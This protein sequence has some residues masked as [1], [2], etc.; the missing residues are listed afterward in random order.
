MS[1]YVDHNISIRTDSLDPSALRR[2]ASV[3]GLQ[4]RALQVVT[5]GM[6]T[7]Q[8]LPF[9]IIDDPAVTVHQ[10]LSLLRK[11]SSRAAE[12]K[13]PFFLDIGVGSSLAPLYISDQNKALVIGIDSDTLP[14][15]PY[16]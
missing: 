4:P 5:P 6:Q 11:L 2:E 3:A 16:H 10:K 14:H 8:D 12:D 15:G 1:D 13:T 9:T 7:V